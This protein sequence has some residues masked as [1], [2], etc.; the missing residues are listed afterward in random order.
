MGRRRERREKKGK[1]KGERR[2]EGGEGEGGKGKR[3]KGCWYILILMSSHHPVFE[4]AKVELW[5]R[6]GPFIIIMNVYLH[7]HM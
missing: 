6:P 3:G 2:K 4:N 1:E 5:R 7:V